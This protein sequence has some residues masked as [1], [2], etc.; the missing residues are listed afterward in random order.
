LSSDGRRY[1][2]LRH[3]Q[4]EGLVAVFDLTSCQPYAA[5]AHQRAVQCV[6]LNHNGSR[7]VTLDSR[8]QVFVWSVPDA[9]DRLQ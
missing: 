8:G 5:L 7:A 3:R 4:D 2:A 1:A 6:C 9:P